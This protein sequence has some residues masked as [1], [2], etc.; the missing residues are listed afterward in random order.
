MIAA[1]L[2]ALP[3]EHAA[4]LERIVAEHPRSNALAAVEALDLDADAR[5]LLVEHVALRLRGAASYWSQRAMSDAQMDV[6]RQFE[7]I[8]TEALAAV[9]QLSREDGETS[10]VI[11]GIAVVFAARQL[12]AE[13]LGCVV[14]DAQRLA[15]FDALFSNH[16]AHAR[17]HVRARLH[18][19]M[20]A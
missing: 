14:S 13:A 2:P 19:M 9:N 5:G 10:A 15:H 12:Q 17:D 11:G 7:R 20:E 18:K 3:A 1:E 4:L 8:G 6:A 16:I